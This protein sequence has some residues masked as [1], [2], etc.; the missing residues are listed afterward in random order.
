MRKPVIVC[1]LVLCLCLVFGRSVW[2]N[3]CGF[4]GPGAG[5]IVLFPNTE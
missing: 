1:T 4:P 5:V 3:H 2:A